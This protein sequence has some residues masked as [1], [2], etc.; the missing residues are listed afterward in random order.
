MRLSVAPTSTT[1][2]PYIDTTKVDKLR[3]CWRKWSIYFFFFSF[4]DFWRHFYGN[5]FRWEKASV[6]TTCTSWILSVPL[7]QSSHMR[8]SPF[9]SEFSV[10]SIVL[11]EEYP[12]GCTFLSW[13]AL[14]WFIKGSSRM[15]EVVKY[16]TA[17]S[18]TSLRRSLWKVVMR[19][20]FLKSRDLHIEILVLHPY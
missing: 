9:C 12:T 3:R 1:R 11:L 14:P 19:L 2:R 10:V 16:F 5:L 6:F 4:S 7:C 15:C 13:T 18:E 8:R 17:R 20:P